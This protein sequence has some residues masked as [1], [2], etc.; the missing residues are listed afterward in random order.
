MDAST[1]R[2]GSTSQPRIV[3]VGAG[4]SGMLMAIRLLGA[5][6]RDVEVLEKADSVGGTW[7]ENTY[8]GLACDVPG[9][10]YAYSFEPNPECGARYAKGPEIQAYFERV[11]AKYRLASH[12]RFG[13]DVVSA[14]YESAGWTIRTGD[15]R[16][17]RAD[18]V[19]AATGVLHHPNLPDL[20]GLASFEGACFHSARWDHGVPLDG[21]RI[22]VVGTGS[23]AVQIVCGTAARAGSLALFQRTAQWVIPAF[24][25]P[26]GETRRAVLRRIPPLNRALHRGYASFYDGVLGA[27]FGA[28]RTLFFKGFE[29]LAERHLGTVRDPDLR[30][31]LTPDHR[32]GCKRFILSDGFY[33]AMQRSNV[34]LVTDRIARIEPAGVRTADGRLHPLDVLVLAT[35]FKAQHYMRPMQLVGRDGLTIDRAWE[36]GVAAYRGVALPGFPNFF[37]L[38]GPNSPIGNYSLI[39]IAEA[40]SSYV[41]QLLDRIRHGDARTIEPRVDATERFN[42]E[43]HDAAGTTI[44]KSDGCSSW[45]LDARGRLTIWPWSLARF[46]AEMKTPAFEDFALTAPA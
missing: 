43:L 39:K 41:M 25:T 15:G 45:Y 40:Q 7:R 17:R 8:P 11:F 42:R 28:D 14:H 31:R 30:R 27:G 21:K 19:I 18:V 23:T 13:A 37:L 9:Y 26:Y 33:D 44:W 22:G 35:G 20:E 46:E 36:G 3:I 34:A 24:D 29:A 32:L 12:V 38:Q 5:G 4:M 6:Y 16:V 1:G 2:D 10:L